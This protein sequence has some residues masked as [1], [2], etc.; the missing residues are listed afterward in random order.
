MTAPAQATVVLCFLVATC[1][2]LDLQAAGMAAEGLRPLFRPS[3]AALSFFFAGGTVGLFLGALIGGRFADTHGR[4]R[5]L[6]AS[7]ALFGLFSLCSPFA[8]DMGSLIGLRILTGLGLGSALPN[9]IALV[10]ETAPAHLRNASVAAVYAGTPFGASVA[11]A[12]SLAA[13]PAH[14]QAIFLIGGMVPLMLVPVMHSK[15][16]ESPVF[17]RMRDAA[18][19]GVAVADHAIRRPAPARFGALFADDRATPTMLLWASCF[20]SLP[21][22]YLLLNWLPTLLRN[23]GIGSSRVAAVQIG[24]NLGGALAAIAAG[25]FFEGRARRATVLAVFITLPIFLYALAR[26]PHDFVTLSSIVFALGC[27][28]AAGQ[29]FFYTV[30][31]AIYAAPIRGLGVGAAVAVGRF[32]S[33]VGPLL[34]GLLVATI[35]DSAASLMR[36]LPVAIASSACAILLASIVRPT[37]STSHGGLMLRL[38]TSKHADGSPTPLI[39]QIATGHVV[40]AALHVVLRLGIPDRLSSGPRTIAELARDSR[41]HEDALYRVM[42]ALASVGIFEEMSTRRFR[43]TAAGEMLRQEVPGSYHALALWWT[44][45]FG[46][47]VFA[48]LMHSVRTGQPAAESVTGMPIFDYFTRHPEVSTMFNEAMS[49]FSDVVV[50][51]A[52]K[53]YDFSGINL[54]VDV[55]GG[56]GAVL[57]AILRAYPRMQGVLFDLDHVTAGAR[58]RIEA[59]GLH[60]RCRAESGDIFTSVP[61]GGDAY[62]MK[63]I[64]HD[65]DDER[66]GVILRNIR[67]ALHDRPGRVILLERLM[68]AGNEPD[69]NKVYDLQMLAGPGGR[70][71]T[72]DEFR[73]LFARSGFALTRVVPTASPLSVIEA[74]WR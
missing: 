69:F 30:A 64:I 40:A 21:T 56:H 14:W 46:F 47:Q 7:V 58:P 13:G 23:A 45:P 63:H 44:A 65:W 26:V 70:E 61:A 28:A 43:L 29:A 68:A 34:G 1:E 24:F 19:P 6:V 36:L 18:H 41:T 73:S 25:R 2:G 33:V 10:S 38:P 9:V 31:P 8:P 5:V 67:T 53:A 42:R 49:G 35:A 59:A 62:I 3:H 27:V 48:D 39:D 11:G 32:G 52:L 66:A 55:A 72:E 16:P 60:D 71:R 54:L 51:A 15:L 20:L 74:E 4:A 37:P 22:I 50:A 17:E 12:I 57:T